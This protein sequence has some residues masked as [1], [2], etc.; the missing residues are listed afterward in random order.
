MAMPALTAVGEEMYEALDPLVRD[1]VD[2]ANDFTAAKFCDARAVMFDEVAGIVRDQDDGTTGYAIVLDPYRCPAK[3]LPWLAQWEGV[4]IPPGMADDETRV[5][6]DEAPA[7]QRGGP[8]AIVSL[9]QRYLT[10]TRTVTLYERLNGNPAVLGIRTR[11]AETPDPALLL[12]AVVKWQK[13]GGVVIDYATV[14]GATYGE[15][16]AAAATYTIAEGASATYL[17]AEGT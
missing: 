3:L 16:E 8:W 12:A 2:E 11:I 14:T 15:A 7:Q 4:E 6:I 10:G 5:L 9:A 13:P 17:I 1:G